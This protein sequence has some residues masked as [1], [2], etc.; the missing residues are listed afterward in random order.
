MASKIFL[1]ANILLDLTLKRA[2][3]DEA[4]MI[5]DMVI[6]GSSQAFTTSSV[7]H[8]AGYYMTKSYGSKKAK[9][10]LL[11]IL[12]DVTIIDLSHEMAIVALSSNLEDI[13]DSLQYYA[14]IHHK[15]DYFISSDKKLQKESIPILPVYTPTEF[16]KEFS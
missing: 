4:T 8:I 5:L 6:S 10:L 15:I 13:E 1:D 9:D 12:M 16:I 14:A 11:G 3:Y 7:I 2:G